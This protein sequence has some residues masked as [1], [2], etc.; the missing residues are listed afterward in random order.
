MSTLKEELVSCDITLTPNTVPPTEV[1][2]MTQTT[3]DLRTGG[4]GQCFF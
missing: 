2:R 4:N 1:K 3:S